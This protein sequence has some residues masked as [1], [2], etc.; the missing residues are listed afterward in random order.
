MG[1]SY[2]DLFLKQLCLVIA[3][4]KVRSSS[5][6]VSA[7]S[8]VSHTCQMNKKLT[9]VAKCKFE[10]SKSGQFFLPRTMKKNIEK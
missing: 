6:I 3:K 10:G 9:I 1:G 2:F 4:N 5:R 7:E 8:I